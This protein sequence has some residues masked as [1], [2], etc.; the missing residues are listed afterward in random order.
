MEMAIKLD[1]TIN[2]LFAILLLTGDNKLTWQTSKPIQTLFLFFVLS[3]N[4]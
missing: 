2:L 4:N 3:E 1:L